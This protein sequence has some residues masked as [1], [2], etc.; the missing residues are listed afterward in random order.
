MTDMTPEQLRRA[1]TTAMESKAHA[2]ALM[3]ELERT[4][5]VDDANLRQRALTAWRAAQA[6]ERI[7]REAPLEAIAKAMGGPKAVEVK[8]LGVD[9]LVTAYVRWDDGEHPGAIAS[10]LGV[11]EQTL[12]DALK[13][14]RNGTT[15]LAKRAR[16]LGMWPRGKESA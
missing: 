10:D 11:H 7:V 8:R 14:W 16:K 12:R 6:D 9:E 3:A 4:P 1:V 2:K 5:A 13:G 15:T